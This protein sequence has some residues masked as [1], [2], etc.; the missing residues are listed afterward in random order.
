MRAASRSSVSGRQRADGAG[1]ISGG[2][3]RDDD[4]RRAG[5]AVQ[6]SPQLRG[7]GGDGLR[8]TWAADTDS[9]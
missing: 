4:G 6:R 7:S 2:F 1:R 3:S 5:G 8:L 9:V